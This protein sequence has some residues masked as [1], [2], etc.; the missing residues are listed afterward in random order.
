MY[1]FSLTS[2]STLPA[3]LRGLGALTLALAV[4]LLL[5]GCDASGGL[6][7]DNTETVSPEETAEAIAFSLAESTGGTADELGDAAALAGG[8]TSSAAAAKDITRSRECTYDDSARRW[9]CDV[10]VNGSRGR[11]DQVDFDRVYRAQFFA[12]TTPVRQPAE[13]DSMTFEI[14]EGSGRVQTARID[15]AH[16]LQP[17]TWAL[18]GTQGTTYTINLL[19]ETAGR[20]V[21]EQFTGPRRERTRTAEVR[22]TRVNDLVWR[23]GEGLVGGT[24]E[25]AYDATVELTRADDSTVTRTVNVTYVA[26]FS[27]DGGEITFTGGGERF[28]G[29]T[30]AFDVGTGQLE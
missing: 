21:D 3:Q 1:R 14:V 24:I 8:A 6:S 4:V 12:G 10:Q 30:F 5:A 20:N 23:D 11:V 17:S 16:E 25:G 18:S 7:D 29:Q 28:N 22:K 9:T 13:A 27:E 15:N 2:T 26:T 19:S